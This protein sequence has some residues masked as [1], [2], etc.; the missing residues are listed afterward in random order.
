MS[1]IQH[2][3]D[4]ATADIDLL[5][6]NDAQGDVFARPRMVDFLLIAPD[7]EKANLVAGFV[8]DFGFGAASVD[9]QTGD[10]RILVQVEMPTTQH[11]LQS[12]SGFMQCLADLYG[13]QYDGW[14]CVLQNT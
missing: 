1:T 9:S 4:N 12:V 5:T 13:L 8:N 14:G 3:I 6:K 11:V 2:L 7:E 10:H